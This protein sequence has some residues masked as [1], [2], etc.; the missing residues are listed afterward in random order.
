MKQATS[1]CTVE[2]FGWKL[3]KMALPAGH[4]YG[5]I[6]G[7]DRDRAAVGTVT[8][9]T[10]G[11]ITG[12]NVSTGEQLDVREPGVLST[13]LGPLKAGKRVLTAEDAAEWWCIDERVNG[14]S[15]P[16]VSLV[17]A[18]AGQLVPGLCF[19]ASGISEGFWGPDCVA[20]D[21]CYVLVFD[22]E[23]A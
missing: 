4:S 17:R 2:A 12:V 14:F 11:R 16:A 22:R 19:V 1:L 23:R 3:V 8:L 9:F 13:T 21:D 15:L 5:L 10:K 7:A 6:V 18:A 20:Q